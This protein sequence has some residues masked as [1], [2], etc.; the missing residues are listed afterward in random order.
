MVEW[1][2]CAELS[3]KIYHRLN[4]R[5]VVKWKILNL[6]NEINQSEIKIIEKQ[7]NVIEQY[8]ISRKTCKRYLIENRISLT[9]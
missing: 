1:H 9:G 8:K 2:L 7:E 6:C 3:F 5:K 4:F